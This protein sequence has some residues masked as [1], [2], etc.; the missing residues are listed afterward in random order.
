MRRRDRHRAF[1]LAHPIVGLLLHTLL[2]STSGSSYPG[3]SGKFQSVAA[4]QPYGTVLLGS[5]FDY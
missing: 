5:S 2:Q 1:P 4:A 3:L